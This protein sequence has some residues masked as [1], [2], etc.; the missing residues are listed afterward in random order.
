MLAQQPAWGATAVLLE[1]SP[2]GLL[3]LFHGY[4]KPVAKVAG[5]GCALGAYGSIAGAVTSHGRGTG[6]QLEYVLLFAALAGL[7]GV[8]GL[9]FL[10]GRCICI[11]PGRSMKIASTETCQRSNTTLK[12]QPS[13][14]GTRGKP[15]APYLHARALCAWRKL[16]GL[17]LH[18][19]G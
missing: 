11:S 18:C 5:I 2:V 14:A 19:A 4:R 17:L 8:L 13:A 9:G 3:V 12:A 1:S 6:V 10:D 15:R 16:F 7:L